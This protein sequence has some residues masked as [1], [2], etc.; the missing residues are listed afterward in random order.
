L[1]GIAEGMLGED[2]DITMRVGRLGYQ[3]VSDPAIKA[4]SEQP[5]NFRDLREQRMRWSF[6]LFN[7]ISRNRDAIFGLDG[8]R[9]LWVMPWACF[10]MFRKLIL[11]PFAV[12]VL[13]L[14]LMD[15][16]F[17]PLHEIAAAGAI[18]L[19]AQLLVMA[20][21]VSI[22]GGPALVVSLPSYIVFRL[23][24]TYFALE[25]LLTAVVKEPHW[26]TALRPAQQRRLAVAGAG[27]T[28]PPQPSQS[29]GPPEPR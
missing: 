28:P 2:A 3:I 10:V 13:G 8:L 20:V 11:I 22:L 23:I 18:A 14:I 9:G 19:G 1:G 5:Q 7:S 26:W 21:V 16:S 12:A 24:V 29:S 17:F 25:T 4:Y 15:D 27:A 6:G